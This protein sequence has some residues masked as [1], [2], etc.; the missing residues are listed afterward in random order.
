MPALGFRCGDI[1]VNADE[2]RAAIGSA[3]VFFGEQR[4]EVMG[5]SFPIVAQAVPDLFLGLVVVGDGKR[6]EVEAN[7]TGAV[8]F[9]EARCDVGEFQPLANSNSCCAN[10]KTGRSGRRASKIPLR[11]SL[12]SEGFNQWITKSPKTLI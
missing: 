4:T 3:D 5:A 9:D 2:A 7:F 6:F 1:S 11:D 12:N 8:G 10:G